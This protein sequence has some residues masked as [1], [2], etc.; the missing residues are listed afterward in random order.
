VDINVVDQWLIRYSVFSVYCIW[1]RN[2]L[3]QYTELLS[4]LK[5]IYYSVTKG[6]LH[7]IQQTSNAA[8]WHREWI[9]VFTIWIN[10]MNNPLQFKL[11]KV[12]ENWSSRAWFQAL[13]AK[14]M[15]PSFFQDVTQCW[16]VVRYWYFESAYQSHLQGSSFKFAVNSFIHGIMHPKEREIDS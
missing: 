3:G 15:R 14:Y 11:W 6:L 5:N 8:L 4:K 7:N 2:T 16:L 12:N 13:A 1:T 9:M 10:S